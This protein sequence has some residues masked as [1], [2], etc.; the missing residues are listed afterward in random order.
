VCIFWITLL[1]IAKPLVI[2]DDDYQ[3][4]SYRSIEFTSFVWLVGLVWVLWDLSVLLAYVYKLNQIR[5]NTKGDLAINQ[6]SAVLHKIIVLTILFRMS[7]LDNWLLFRFVPAHIFSEY[8]D[9]ILWP[10]DILQTLFII[11]FMLDS[12]HKKYV[13]LVRC[14][15]CLCNRNV[16]NEPINVTLKTGTKNEP[17][18]NAIEIEIKTQAKDTSKSMTMTSAQKR[19]SSD[20]DN[21]RIVKNQKVS[22]QR[23][24]DERMSK[25]NEASL[26]FS[27]PTDTSSIHRSSAM[28]S[29]N[30]IIEEVMTTVI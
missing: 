20:L 30:L 10:L 12:N 17:S 6:V 9:R 16:Q 24:R 21:I 15:C 2:Y 29:G 1:L 19:T 18:T 3:C 27:M 22:R 5:L 28:C 14:F 4:K 13:T 7:Q 23:H 26:E 25:E 8:I 11:Y